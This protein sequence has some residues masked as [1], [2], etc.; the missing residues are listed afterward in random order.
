[1]VRPTGPVRKGT[2]P[3]TQRWARVLLVQQLLLCAALPAFAQQRALQ[4][5]DAYRLAN[6]G[7]VALSPTGA[8]VAFTVTTVN[9]KDNNR[10]TAIWLQELRNGRPVG[11]PVRFT[12]PTRNSTSPTWSPDGSVLGFTSRRGD[13]DEGTTWFLRVGRLGG[14]AYRIEGVRGTP[15]WSPD[16]RSIAYTAEPPEEK[17]PAAKALRIAPDA[18]TKPLDAERFDGYVI[19]HRR[20][21]RDG[22]FTFIPHPGHNRKRQLWVVPATGGEARQV[23]NLS[24]N[25]GSFEWSPDGSWFVYSVN[26]EEDDDMSLDP[27]SSIWVVPAAGGEPR[28]VID[29]PGGQ[30][31]PAISPDGSK[32]AFTHTPAWNSETFLMVVDID[33]DGVARGEPRNLTAAWGRTA[34]APRW[35]ADGRSVRWTSVVDANAN[36]YEVAAAGGAVRQ[37]TQGERVLGN[38]SVSANGRLMAY[39]STDPTRPAD[40][41]VA[42]G[43]GRN[44]VRIT[45]FNDAL[46]AEV[47]RQPAERITWR[48]R[49]GTEIEG[50]VIKPAN[51]QP[52][53]R[54]P[55]VLNIHGGPHAAYTSSFSAPFHI[56]SGAGFFVFYLNPRGSTSY[57]NDFKHAIHAAWGVVDEEDFITG[58]ETVLSAYPDIDR[59]RLG[60]TGGSYGGFMTNWLT[61]RTKLFAAA[62]TRASISSWEAMAGTTDSNQ[63]HR[64]FDGAY[65]EQRDVWRRNSP[66]SYVENVTAPTLVIHGENDFRTP[67]SEGQMWYGALKKLGVPAEFVIYPRSGH[68]IN[69]PWLAADVQE[70]TRQWLVHWLIEN[71]GKPRAE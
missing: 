37:V 15:A 2:I 39:T 45:S 16:G 50:W 18:L 61:A 27:S 63:P 38:L 52:G 69:E 9:E 14:E 71:P 43:S 4:P 55:M 36:V 20:Y 34:S 51:Y 28:R 59:S 19:T 6:V 68:G 40:V 41:F 60:V 26:P 21:K 42:D 49:D 64:A 30:S 29:L 32:L 10:S 44:E 8:H 57:G 31:A 17:K 33:A 58:V 54:Y 1:M 12:D 67:L 3:R 48:V 5:Q 25:V 70:R 35:S 46:L 65:H 66:I 13:D 56:L 62:V 7:G 47:A 23:T 24:Y 53:T 11:E 22:T